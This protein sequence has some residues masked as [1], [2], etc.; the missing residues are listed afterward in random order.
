MEV[1]AARL[2]L[3]HLPGGQDLVGLWKETLPKTTSEFS[4]EAV[5]ELPRLRATQH[6]LCPAKAVGHIGW[7]ERWVPARAAGPRLFSPGLVADP[8]PSPQ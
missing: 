1:L 2:A 5:S 6:V 3:W 4:S 8:P 7:T